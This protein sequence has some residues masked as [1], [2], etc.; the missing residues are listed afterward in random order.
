MTNENKPPRTM[1][2]MW[3]FAQQ[4]EAQ[5]ATLQE[6]NKALREQ[7]ATKLVKISGNDIDTLLNI[8][9]LLATYCPFME[10][11]P[12]GDLPSEAQVNEVRDLIVRICGQ[13]KA[14]SV[15]GEAK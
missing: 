2:H 10:T 5:I 12:S 7:L 3:S 11:P 6:E 1:P 8:F 15:K 9:Y 14:D 13:I 4:R